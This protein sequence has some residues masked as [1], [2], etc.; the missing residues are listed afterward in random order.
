MFIRELLDDSD[1]HSDV[2]SDTY[3]SEIVIAGILADW[4]ADREEERVPSIYVRR[5]SPAM[6]PVW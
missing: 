6:V 2:I 1:Y 4:K 5:F 3:F